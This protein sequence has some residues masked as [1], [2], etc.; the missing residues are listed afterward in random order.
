MKNR[1]VIVED[2]K[3]LAAAIEEKLELFSDELEFGY[4]AEN[5]LDALKMLEKDHAIDAILMDIEMPVMNG[6]EA[7]EIITEKYPQI[8]IIILTVFDDEDNIFNAIKAGAKGYLLKDEPPNKIYEGIKM[9]MEGG[10]PMSPVI[11][12][13]SLEMLRNPRSLSSDVTE[14]KYTL[15]KRET[16]VLEQ[17]SKGHDYNKIAENLFISPST[18]RKHIENIYGKLQV[19][20]KMQAVQK[21]I[22]HKLI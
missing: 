4:H 19:H 7:T 14:E 17:L 20:N 9:I 8:K 6:I 1:I 5:G 21:A 11:A 22:K 10:A 18:V 2:N 3:L 13:K 16:E 15:S 12:A